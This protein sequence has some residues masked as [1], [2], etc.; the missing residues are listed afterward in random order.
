[1]EVLTVTWPG[2][3][4]FANASSDPLFQYF[5]YLIGCPVSYSYGGHFLAIKLALYR[6]A[7]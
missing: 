5:I 1:M 6:C 2:D 3:E 4:I 7:I